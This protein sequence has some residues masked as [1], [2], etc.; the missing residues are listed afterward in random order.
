MQ[1]HILTRGHSFKLP[2]PICRSEICCRFFNVRIVST[3]NSLPV[4]IVDT[5]SLY[6]FKAR[7]DCHMSAHCFQTLEEV[8]IM[9][10]NILFRVM[11]YVVIYVMG[12]VKSEFGG[13][14]DE[15]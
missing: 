12:W 8:T 9:F 1:S 15:V 14:I 6:S 10:F 11:V 7:L 3:W 5:G 2:V 13:V 4:G